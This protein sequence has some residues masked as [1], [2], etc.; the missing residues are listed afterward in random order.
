MIIVDF[1]FRLKDALKIANLTPS[2]DELKA[3]FEVIVRMTKENSV[4]RLETESTY[5]DFLEKDNNKLGLSETNV[6][7]HKSPNIKLLFE[8]LNHT[9]VI[10]LMKGVS[11]F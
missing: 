8:N 10:D 2:S 5:R 11:V 9:N 4:D 6:L 7:M 1:D 3:F